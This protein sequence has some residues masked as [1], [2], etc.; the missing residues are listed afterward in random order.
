[1]CIKSYRG[2]LISVHIGQIESLLV[3]IK[4]KSNFIH[5]II[6]KTAECNVEKIVYGLQYINAETN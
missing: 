2:N 4:F 1:M 3:Y 5:F 6:L